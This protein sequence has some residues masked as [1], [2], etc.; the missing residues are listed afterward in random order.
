MPLAPPPKLFSI[1]FVLFSSHTSPQERA[2]SSTARRVSSL[3]PLCD[4]RV[5]RTAVL[6]P[7][8]LLAMAASGYGGR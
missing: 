5:S 6:H 3:L 8:M 7:V 4:S 2:G 1:L